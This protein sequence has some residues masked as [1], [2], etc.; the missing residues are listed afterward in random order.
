VPAQDGPHA[1][2]S[3]NDTH[4]RQLTLDPARAPSVV[5][6]SQLQNDRNGAGGNVSSTWVVD[7]VP[8]TPD[9]V[10]MPPKEGLGLD[11]ADDGGPPP[12]GGA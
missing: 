5:L 2:R 6:P 11:E 12:R 1:R 8:L 10:P 9:E 4:P 3:Q 7:V